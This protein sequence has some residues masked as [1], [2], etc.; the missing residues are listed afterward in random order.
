[1]RHGREAQNDRL[2]AVV[3]LCP[4]SRLGASSERPLEDTSPC[5]RAAIAAPLGALSVGNPVENDLT[6]RTSGRAERDPGIGGGSWGDTPAWTLASRPGPC[7]SLSPCFSFRGG[8]GSPGSALTLGPTLG[9]VPSISGWLRG[10]NERAHP[11]SAAV[12]G[13]ISFCLPLIVGWFS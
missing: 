9:P 6:R 7:P 12:P 8:L 10:P 11:R 13:L 4:S 3:F 2:V 1:M 5:T